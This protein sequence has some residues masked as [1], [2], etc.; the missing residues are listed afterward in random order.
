MFGDCP[1]RQIA[2]R[3]RALHLTP[4]PRPL[5]HWT[6]QYVRVPAAMGSGNVEAVGTLEVDAKVGDWDAWTQKARLLA[7]WVWEGKSRSGRRWE[8]VDMA[9]GA[10]ALRGVEVERCVKPGVWKS[11]LK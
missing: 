7:G 9:E 3:S 1:R 6:L 10:V 2:H 11:V 4:L 5:S 8:A